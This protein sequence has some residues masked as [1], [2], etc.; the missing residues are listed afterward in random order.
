MSDG[1]VAGI[2]EMPATSISETDI[3]GGER[4]TSARRT[5]WSVIFGQKRFDVVRAVEYF[6]GAMVRGLVVN[7]G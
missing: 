3:G 6:G 5:L 7:K 1:E 4:R 2:R